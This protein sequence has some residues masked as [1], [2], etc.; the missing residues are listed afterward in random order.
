MRDL[1]L[2]KIDE[3][4]TRLLT[5]GM[6]IAETF[7]RANP[8]GSRDWFNPADVAVETDPHGK[9]VRATLK[10]DGRPVE[11]GGAEKMSKSKNNGVD[12]QDL[13][14]RFGA[15]TA[16][17]FT[18]RAANPE[19]ML[20]WSDAGVAGSYRFLRRLWEHGQKIGEAIRAVPPVDWAAAPAAVR[21]ARREVHATL[22]KAN[23]DIERIQY[24]TVVS[25][26]DILLNA[27]SGLDTADAHGRA[28]ARE[29]MSILLRLLYPVVPHIG[30]VLWDE[31]GYAAQHG[32]ILDAPWP[33][34]DPT[35]LA[36]DE[37][38]L[39]L[40]VNGKLRGKLVVP[41]TADR[42]AIEALA[43]ASAEVAKHAGGA[44]VKKVVVV[45]GRLVN[46][47]V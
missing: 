26:G 3:P 36:Q 41:A 10:S 44:A 8:D 37:I 22:N 43:R 47:V 29:G 18:M 40:Q 14:D 32:P 5:Q 11:M 6:V 24:N 42:A 1:G 39:V 9:P 45:P 17:H 12:P 15:D 27:L 20:T 46:V 2:V 23:Y 4:F 31:L 25:A 21:A 28:L 34:V 35:A 13:I 33:E 7:Y 19:D 16:R 38:E 30:H